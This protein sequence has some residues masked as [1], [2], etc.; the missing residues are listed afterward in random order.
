M[1]GQRPQNDLHGSIGDQE[2]FTRWAEKLDESVA[3]IVKEAAMEADPAH[4][5]A[6][7]IQ[8]LRCAA[9]NLLKLRMANDTADEVLRQQFDLWPALG[10]VAN[11]VEDCKEATQQAAE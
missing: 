11:L 1:M 5:V 2:A 6:M 4:R 9:S 8:A 10:V 3:A 7:E